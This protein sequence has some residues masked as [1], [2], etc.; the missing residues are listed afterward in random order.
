[1]QRTQ[2]HVRLRCIRAWFCNVQYAQQ[3]TCMYSCRCGRL[4]VHFQADVIGTNN[5]TGKHRKQLRYKHTDHTHTH[6]L[7]QIRTTYILHCR[8]QPEITAWFQ[9]QPRS[10]SSEEPTQNSPAFGSSRPSLCWEKSA[11]GRPARPPLAPSH[12]PGLQKAEFE[13]EFKAR[14]PVTAGLTRLRTRRCDTL[15]LGVFSSG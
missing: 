4:A 13:D 14:V 9:G 5:H 8:Y 12:G 11:S 6:M 2:R 15:Q 10:C 1:M 3:N 7:K